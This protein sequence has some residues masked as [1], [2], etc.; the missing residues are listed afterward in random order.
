MRYISTRGQAPARDFTDVLLH[1]LAEDGGLFMP[2]SWPHF[3]PSE[4]RTM[5]GLPYAELAARILQPFAGESISF[6]VLRTICQ[7]SYAGFSHP[8]VVPLIQLETGLF[9]Q[10]LFHGPTLAFKDLAMQV[11]GRLFDHALAERDQRVT[12]VGATSGDTG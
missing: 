5:R 3:G 2:V 8:A 7:Q 11:L 12:I 6:E 9:T 1:G 10:E 4:W